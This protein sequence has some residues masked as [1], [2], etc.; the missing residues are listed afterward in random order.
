MHS[1]F[2]ALYKWQVS[3]FISISLQCCLHLE[4]RTESNWHGSL[5]PS[6]PWRLSLVNLVGFP[7]HIQ[8]LLEKAFGEEGAQ[9]SHSACTKYRKDVYSLVI[10]IW[11][12]FRTWVFTSCVDCLKWASLPTDI[13]LDVQGIDNGGFVSFLSLQGLEAW[14]YWSSRKQVREGEH[15]RKSV[16]RVF[17]HLEVSSLLNYANRYIWATLS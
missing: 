6:L 13:G 2:W 9:A 11:F 4:F 17:L 12:F 15:W 14:S 3:S 1:S 5:G 10:F 7:A 16:A 8:Y